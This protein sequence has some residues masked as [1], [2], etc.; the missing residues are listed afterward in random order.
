[1]RYARWTSFAFLALGA[2][3]GLLAADL[4]EI[5]SRGTLRVIVV[6][7]ERAPEFFSLKPGGN[8]G[9]DREILEAFGKSQGLKLDFVLVPAWDQ[10]VP[11]LLAGRGD[12]VAGRVSNTEG[13]RKLI[14]FTN[15]V[16]P[17]R[18]LVLNRKPQ[19]P[20]E[21]LAQLAAQK[22]GAIKGTSMVE[23]LQAAG[24]PA[25]RVNTEFDVSTL[26]EGLA[27]GQITA[28]V[29]AV[30]GAILAQRKDA[31]VQ[32]GMFL[33]PPES[34]AYGVPKES[35]LL[36]AALN[37]HI[38]LVKQSGTWNR[39]TITYFGGAAPQILKRARDT[40]SG[41]VP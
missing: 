7:E 16:F 33:G 37:E 31:A 39:L 14:D 21:T 20:I 30:E 12:L 2:S 15:E 6:L 1:M 13:R 9:I 18:V 8:P 40:A 25:S 41:G 11:S 24:I 22:I 27:S 34:L 29:W 28:A 23:A 32:L 35:P 26:M 10:L 19:P 5:K 38:R 17:S 3:T 4:P 36:R